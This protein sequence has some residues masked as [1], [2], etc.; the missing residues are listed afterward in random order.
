MVLAGWFSP[1]NNLKCNTSKRNEKPILDLFKL[2]GVLLLKQI[3]TK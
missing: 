3:I 1:R 2:N